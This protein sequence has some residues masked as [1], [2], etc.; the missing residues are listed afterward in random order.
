MDRFTAKALL[1][2]FDIP[3]SKAEL[4]EVENLLSRK[5]RS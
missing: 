1:E 4:A 5:F 3:Q 2:I